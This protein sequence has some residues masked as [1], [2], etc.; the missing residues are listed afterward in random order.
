[1]QPGSAGLLPGQNGPGPASRF[2]RSVSRAGSSDGFDA[3]AYVSVCERKTGEAFALAA[4]LG[5]LAAGVDD[6]EYRKF[7]LAYGI[8]FQIDD[9]VADGASHSGLADLRREWAAALEALPATAR[10]RRHFA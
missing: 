8:L 9:D 6:A 1:M 5:A 2:T 3:A 7:G 10:V 4:Q